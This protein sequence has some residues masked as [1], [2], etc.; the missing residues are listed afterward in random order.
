MSASTIQMLGIINIDEL[1]PYFSAKYELEVN[2][3]I[4][5]RNDKSALKVAILFPPYFTFAG[6]GQSPAR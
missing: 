5:K 1:N 4:P 6:R 2:A 3:T